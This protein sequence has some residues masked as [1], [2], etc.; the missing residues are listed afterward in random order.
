MRMVLHRGSE[1]GQPAAGQVAAPQPAWGLKSHPRVVFHVKGYLINFL[2]L[3]SFSILFKVYHGKSFQK[4]I[5][6][7]KAVISV[8]R[9]LGK[10]EHF[11]LMHILLS[12]CFH[13]SLSLGTDL[14]FL[15]SSPLKESHWDSNHHKSHWNRIH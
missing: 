12:I 10:M 8:L 11:A 9:L 14:P 1:L 3:S 13:F 7:H 6:P 15:P 2:K 5:F 4:C